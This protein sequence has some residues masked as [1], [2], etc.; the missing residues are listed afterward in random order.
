MPQPQSLLE[1]LDALESRARQFQAEGKHELAA[2]LALVAA[3]V[4]KAAGLLKTL[5]DVPNQRTLIVDMAH[6]ALTGEPRR[7]GRPTKS[8]HPF[9]LALEAKGTTV[10]EWAREHDVEREVVKSWFAPPPSG[11]RIPSRWAVVIQRELGIPATDDSWPN[12]I[13]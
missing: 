9:P 4:R 5:Q 3:D 1:I 2:E 12:G 10:A 6:Q 11:R 8:K 7:R 13:R